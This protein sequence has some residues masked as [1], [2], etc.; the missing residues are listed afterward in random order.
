VP[1]DRARDSLRRGPLAGSLTVRIARQTYRPV[2]QQPP[3]K[4]PQAALPPAGRSVGP[5]PGIRDRRAR[6]VAEHLSGNGGV[7]QSRPPR[8]QDV[9]ELRFSMASP[10]CLLTSRRDPL[11]EGSLV[12]A[13]ASAALPRVG[14]RWRRVVLTS[15]TRMPR[16]SMARHAAAMQG[17]WPVPCPCPHGSECSSWLGVS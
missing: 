5:E 11:S 14:R 10:S 9:G 8:D 6:L 4:P 2:S 1:Q 7:S 16:G 13:V 15:A 3:A 12:R 17:A